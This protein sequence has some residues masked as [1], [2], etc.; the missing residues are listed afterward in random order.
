MPITPFHFGPGL[1]FKSYA[2]ARLSWTV[3]ALANILTDLEP[4]AWYL[5]SGEPAHRQLHSYLGAAAVALVAV[6]PGRRMAE[7]CLAW[8][9]R[10]LSPK[11]ARWLGTDTRIPLGAAWTGAL[12]GSFSH[13]L[14]DSFM[15]ADL[16]PLWPW[17]AGNALLNGISLDGL[18]LAC[19]AAG[20]WGALRLGL[21]HWLQLPANSTGRILRAAGRLV[22]QV[23]AGAMLLLAVVFAATLAS[24]TRITDS[25]TFDAAVWRQTAPRQLRN[26]PRV[27]MAQA[28]VRQLRAQRP[29]RAGALAL[30]GTPDAGNHPARASYHLGFSTWLAMDPDTLDIEFSA[31]GGFVDAR[32]VQH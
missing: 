27:P 31:D 14:L 25:A 8:W 23:A 21:R 13:V 22:D 10:H 9:N 28:A 29:S 3:F 15:H 7:A 11:Q 4:V 32:I 2:P 1:L 5:L 17:A 6:W 30:L 12:L 20:L 24:S 26:N 18:H 16:Q 19:A